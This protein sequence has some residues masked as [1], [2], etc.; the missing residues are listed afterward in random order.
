[1]RSRISKN[2]C[3]DFLAEQKR[4]KDE[5]TIVM[6][7]L[8]FFVYFWVSK[9]CDPIVSKYEYPIF[10][11][12]YRN[13]TFEIQL[14]VLGQYNDREKVEVKTVTRKIKA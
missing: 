3:D 2:E 6:E 10:V 7:W 14:D 5:N 11:R 12:G 1:M 8:C 13:K 9:L 4:P